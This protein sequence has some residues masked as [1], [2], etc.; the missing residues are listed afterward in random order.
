MEVLLTTQTNL[1]LFKSTSFRENVQT[2]STVLIN[3]NVP[4]GYAL[5]H[6]QILNV[7]L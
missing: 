6:D 7:D 5:N 3:L 1:I 2:E 4:H